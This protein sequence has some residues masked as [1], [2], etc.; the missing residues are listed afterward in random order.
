MANELKGILLENKLDFMQ[1]KNFDKE[2]ALRQKG[3]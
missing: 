2:G 1:R 3:I